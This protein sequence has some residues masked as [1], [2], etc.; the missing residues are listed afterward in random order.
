ML[1]ASL[2]RRWAD[3]AYH[4]VAD[5][6]WSVL[7]GAVAVHAAGS[8]A[9]L[10][11]AGE[12]K[13]TTPVDFLY[14]YATTAY[15][16]GYGDVSPQTPAGRLVTALVVFPGAIA[17]F[18]TVVAKS[19][20]GMGEFWRRRRNG[21][22]DFARMS[23]TIVLV[24]FD[25]ERT[26]KMIAELH[27]DPALRSRVVLLTRKEIAD[28]DERVR[29]VRAQ[30][31][32]SPAELKR[33]GVENAAR[34]AIYADTDAET[35]S[36]ALAVVALSPAAHVVCY[37]QDDDNAELLKLHCPEVECVV[38]PGAELVVRSVQD[39]GAS[40]VL[41]ALI[42][43]LDRS[44]TLFSVEW[45]AG[46][47]TTFRAA[48]EAFLDQGATL[49]ACRRAGEPEPCFNPSSEAPIAPGDKLF[50]VAD[51]RVRLAPAKAAA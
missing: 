34:V 24:G 1:F 25:P 8:W 51:H 28:P 35:L 14:W 38:A 7:A 20:N 33:A 40:R 42:S 12:P 10:A 43:H 31:L 5:L 45:P 48:V 11:A 46:P 16:V 6:H 22:G 3:R 17:A 9:L 36:A 23:D 29:Y 18:T 19:L 50:Y 41:G 49:L 2:V 37:F 47:S 26:P 15:T 30:S 4:A 13:L 44:A 32:T 21:K 27:A 39:P